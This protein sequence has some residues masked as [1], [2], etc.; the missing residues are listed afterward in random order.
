[1]TVD[2]SSADSGQS[3]IVFINGLWHTSG[4]WKRWADRYSKAGYQVLVPDWPGM[5]VDIDVLRKDPSVMNGLGV[6]EIADHYE[7][8][9]RELAAPPILIGHSL[10]GL[11]VEILLDRGLGSAGVAIHPGPAKGVRRLPL[12][13]LRVAFPVLRNPANRKRTVALTP[14]QWYYAMDNT[15][16][17][18]ES[19]ASYDE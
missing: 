3:T 16:S 13:S 2:D 5:D 1:M 15:L 4:S 19:R 17:A 11:L 7:A 18:Q 8:I 10:G 12:S 6:T 14:K 9:I